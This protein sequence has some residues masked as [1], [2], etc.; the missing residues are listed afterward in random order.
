MGK[1]S[2]NVGLKSNIGNI[3]S[4]RTH[5]TG[6]RVSHKYSNSRCI[7][8]NLSLSNV[9]REEWKHLTAEINQMEL[10]L[11]TREKAS[12]SKIS[13]GVDLCQCSH[14]PPDSMLGNFAPENIKKLSKCKTETLHAF[15]QKAS[16][17]INVC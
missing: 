4:S 2:S 15:D 7:S 9:C 13:D 14:I 17:L 12:K 6:R 16:L 5:S 11:K 1:Y 8:S 3:Y 10:Q